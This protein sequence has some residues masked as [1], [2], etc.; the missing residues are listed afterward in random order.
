MKKT[1]VIWAFFVAAL[2]AGTVCGQHKAQAGAYLK[3][4][5]NLIKDSSFEGILNS[6]LEN[7]QVKGK[8]HSGVH[9]LQLSLTNEQIEHK[10][11]CILGL[12]PITVKPESLYKIEAWVHIPKDITTP[13]KDRSAFFESDKL[14]FY[15]AFVRGTL[16]N[17]EG[18]Q[19]GEG[20]FGTQLYGKSKAQID[21]AHNTYGGWIQLRGLIKTTA[22]TKY[23]KIRFGLEEDAGTV[24]FDDVSLRE[25]DNHDDYLC[26]F[27]TAQAR[28]K[29]IGWWK[30]SGYGMFPIFGLYSVH[31]G[32][33]KGQYWPNSLAEWVTY[34]ADVSQ[35][36][37]MALAQV[38]RPHAFDA[39]EFVRLAKEAGMGHIVITA[40][41][42]DGFAM[43]PTKYDKFNLKDCGGFERDIMDELA[44]ACRK[45]GIHFG[46]YYSQS[47][48]WYTPGGFNRRYYTFGKR[49]ENMSRQ[50][51][52]RHMEADIAP[53]ELTRN[54]L[55]NKSKPQ[56][57]ELMEN[58]N[59]EVI[60]FDVP[61][62]INIIDALE[63]LAIV[64]TYNPH[65]VAGSRLHASG[66]LKDF[67]TLGDY[68]IPKEQITEPYWE[69]LPGMQKNTYSY[70][71][72]QPFRSPEEIF[73]ELK[74]VRA[75]GGNYLLA[76]G[77]PRGDGSI[78]EKNFEI[79]RQVKEMADKEGLFK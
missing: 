45:A 75:K 61:D 6:D 28:D 60:W 16:L 58:Y 57:I 68:T 17:K 31:A 23:L 40:K 71:Q 41:Y 9:A 77:G 29:R 54:Y 32:V 3:Y 48:E 44:K 14:T 5:S 34:R 56:L 65:C 38:F 35:G 67:R 73:A 51:M 62:E 79:L 76:I 70:D 12:E 27:E 36:E 52:Y 69:S 63:L 47:Q 22:D 13:N 21:L 1:V 55:E 30:K 25:I 50:V 15:G 18:K 46:F 11:S 53:L 7:Y 33:W 8:A 10:A 2:T 4:G 49:P 72:F 20:V 24:F 19:I 39:D 59:P 78:P 42:H 43:W 74:T 64:R 26:M 66:K 37:M